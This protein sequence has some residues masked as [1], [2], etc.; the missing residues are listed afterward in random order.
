[1]YARTYVSQHNVRSKS[2]PR[3]LLRENSTESLQSLSHHWKSREVSVLDRD[4][5]KVEE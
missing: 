4:M 5:P 2:V 3:A 1:M